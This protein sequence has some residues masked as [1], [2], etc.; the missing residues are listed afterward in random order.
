MVDFKWLLC[1]INDLKKKNITGT[2]KQQESFHI[3]AVQIN[4]CPCNVFIQM[5]TKH[6]KHKVYNTCNSNLGRNCYSEP[7]NSNMNKPNAFI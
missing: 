6:S 1:Y 3:V 5:H 7:K 2:G 4:N